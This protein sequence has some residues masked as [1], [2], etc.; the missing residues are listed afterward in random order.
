[1][2]STGMWW[3]DLWP[4]RFSQSSHGNRNWGF[5]PH[6]FCIPGGTEKFTH[7]L[8]NIAALFSAMNGSSPQTLQ[9]PNSEYHHNRIFSRLSSFRPHP[10][11]GGGQIR[12]ETPQLCHHRAG[13]PARIPRSDGDTGVLLIRDMM[14]D[15]AA[16]RP[17]K[18]CWC[19]PALLQASVHLLVTAADPGLCERSRSDNR[20]DVHRQSGVARP[21]RRGR[22]H[23]TL[24]HRK[25]ETEGESDTGCRL[26][27]GISETEKS[28]FARR[29]QQSSVDFL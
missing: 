25:R 9:N 27:Q 13:L 12:A 10:V 20:K 8:T 15:A 22:T 5:P 17:S 29:K 3:I 6:L 24:A 14:T 21:D 11:P 7:Q 16:C 19:R 2:S 26:W 1:M 28:D 23:Y 18:V 4:H